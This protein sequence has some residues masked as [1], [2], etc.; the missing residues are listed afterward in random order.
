[1]HFSLPHAVMQALDRLHKCGYDAYIVGGCVRDMLRG[2]APHDFDLCT[3]SLPEETRACFAD[4]R[5]Y[6]TGLQHGTL[7]VLMQGM[8]LEITT[9]RTDGDY[10]DGRHPQSVGFTRSL[11]E[12]LK[13]RDFTINAM[14]YN[15]AKGLVDCFGGQDD[16]QKGVIRCVGDAHTR[17]T[18]DA[19][20][21]LRAVR[22]ASVL[23]FQVAESTAQAM[24]DLHARLSLVSRERIAAEL[25]RAIA[26]E[27]VVP[28]LTAFPD[29]LF[30]ALPD[31]DP[32]A[33]PHA[34]AVLKRLPA[35]DPLLRTAALLYPCGEEKAEASL[36]SLKPST[37]FIT[38]ALALIAHAADTPDESDIPLLLSSLGEEQ[39]HRL[40]MLWRA[41]GIP[42]DVHTCCT[43]RMQRILDLHLPL[44]LSHLAVNGADL[45]RSGVMPGPALGQTL[46]QLHRDVLLE[47]LPND[48]EALLHAIKK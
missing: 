37:Q 28:V 38:Q 1:M 13:R 6:D 11:E 44:T 12:D 36:R 40:L 5:T 33:L 19:L 31:Y 34:L 15:P 43:A 3:S 27:N 42:E 32:A 45:I 25:L 29:V 23:G 47:K 18:E 2:V 20:R 26:A 7:T 14:A 4:E 16:L 21:I 39:M 8:P 17:L 24:H 41:A 10:L 46:L 22:F 48:R 30:S 9:F 35:G